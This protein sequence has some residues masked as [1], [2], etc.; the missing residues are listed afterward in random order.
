MAFDDDLDATS[1]HEPP[2]STFPVQR[3][4]VG[5]TSVP[6]LLRLPNE[7][8]LLV[9]EQLEDELYS[10]ALLSRRLHHLA[11]PVYLAHHGMSASGGEL[12]LFDQNLSALLQGLTIALFSPALKRLSY[13]SY[14]LSFYK[15]ETTFLTEVRGVVRLVSKLSRVDEALLDFANVDWGPKPV[16]Q[17]C[18]LKLSEVTDGESQEEPTEEWA[19]A[20]EELINVVIQKSCSTLTVRLGRL[21]PGGLYLHNMIA[22]IEKRLDPY[23]PV[24]SHFIDPRV[25]KSFRSMLRYG[26]SVKRRNVIDTFNA[27]SSM[28][29]HPDLRNW[30][31]GTLNYSC[32]TTLSLKHLDI[33]PATWSALL[34]CLALPTLSKLSVDFCTITFTDLSRFLV[35]HPQIEHLYL[36][37][38]LSSPQSERRLPKSALCQLTTLTANSEYL[39]HFISP[40]GALPNLASVSVILRIPAGK[41]FDFVGINTTLAPISDRLNQTVL[42]LKLLLESSSAEWMVLDESAVGLG[43]APCLPGVTG[44]E[45]KACSYRLSP[46][47]MSTLPRWLAL[48]PVLKR[49]L[50]TTLSTSGPTEPDFRAAFIR[51]ISKTCPG[52]QSIGINGMEYSVSAW[53]ALRI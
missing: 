38:S 8:L 41:H 32:V 39:V 10:L 21:P 1:K 42:S 50:F 48:F 22:Q 33:S 27:H 43:A 53:L 44:L 30:T 20:F 24:L 34:P 28:L 19:E 2:Q 35:R 37:R 49:V 18:G 31:I 13:T 14:T 6:G 17:H 40:R 47:A 52:I 4:G 12:K 16:D 51:G 3:E 25:L 11:L 36:G 29:F 9:F 23:I 26:R 15:P 5:T 46:L 45:L 7:I